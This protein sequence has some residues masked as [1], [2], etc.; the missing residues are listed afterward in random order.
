[1]KELGIKTKEEIEA[2]FENFEAYLKRV[3][4]AGGKVSFGPQESPANSATGK[5]DEA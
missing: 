5:L 3:D 1:M 4:E 2:Y